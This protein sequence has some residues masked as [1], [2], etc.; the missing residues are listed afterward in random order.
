MDLR[1]SGN[2][3]NFFIVFFTTLK[4]K[5]FSI[6]VREMRAFTFFERQYIILKK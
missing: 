3:F 5:R 2:V 6:N 4:Y 1:Q